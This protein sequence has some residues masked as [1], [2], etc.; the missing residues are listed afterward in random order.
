MLR[1]LLLTFDSACSASGYATLM[2]FIAGLVV[3]PLLLS[4]TRQFKGYYVALGIAAL[5][6]VAGLVGMQYSLGMVQD[7]LPNVPEAQRVAAEACGISVSL[8]PA[9]L[10]TLASAVLLL[11]AV[12]TAAAVGG[13][14]GWFSGEN[15][16]NAVLGIGLSV[17]ALVALVST[18]GWLHGRSLVYDA[19]ANVPAAMRETAKAHGMTVANRWMTGGIIAGAIGLAAT[20]ALAVRAAGTNF[21]AHGARGEG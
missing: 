5:P 2:L 16:R 7:A 12:V 4:F 13:D 21:G 11:V 10:G 3:I 1:F 17:T 15:A 20:L 19:I 6:A 18:A 14:R 8:S 9:G